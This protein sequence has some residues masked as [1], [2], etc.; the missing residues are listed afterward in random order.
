MLAARSDATGYAPVSGILTVPLTIAKA[1]AC[2][3]AAA[4]IAGT[5]LSGVPK[6]G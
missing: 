6:H 1:T 2:L 3:L 4:A 5:R